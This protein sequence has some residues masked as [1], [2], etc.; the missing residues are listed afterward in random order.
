MRGRDFVE[1][2]GY[3]SLTLSKATPGLG[4]GSGALV[5]KLRL[6]VWV[7]P[8][9]HPR[10]IAI[11]NSLGH[12]EYTNVARGVKGTAGIGERAVGMDLAAYRDP[13]WERNMWWEDRSGGDPRRWVKN[14]GN[15]WAQNHVLPIMAD[16]VSGQQAF[17]DTVV[18]VRKV[19]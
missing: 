19:T 3:R 15:G 7:T 6:P 8:G 5:R 12:T 14:R 1:L 4:L 10:A 11:S 17:N 13:D 16:H 2:T 18:T 9:V